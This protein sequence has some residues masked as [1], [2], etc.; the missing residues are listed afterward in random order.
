MKTLGL[1]KN[2]PDKFSKGTRRG[3]AMT[4]E[5]TKSTWTRLQGTPEDEEDATRG[6][7]SNFVQQYHSRGDGVWMDGSNG[8][9]RRTISLRP[10]A[11][12]VAR[13]RTS[14]CGVTFARTVLFSKVTSAKVIFHRTRY[15]RVRAAL[16]C[17]CTTQ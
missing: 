11:S 15:S 1:R 12:W 3:C 4:T 14:R 9:W 8:V 13:Y 10:I 6:K 7:E 17:T 16:A 5:G 2:P